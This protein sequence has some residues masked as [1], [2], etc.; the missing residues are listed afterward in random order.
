MGRLS[1]IRNVIEIGNRCLCRSHALFQLDVRVLRCFSL[2]G[3]YFRLSQL[4]LGFLQL[5]SG[6]VH[7]LHR[8]LVCLSRLL[9]QLLP[10]IEVADGARQQE[11][12]LLRSTAFVFHFL[13]IIVSLRGFDAGL[14]HS[15]NQMSLNLLLSLQHERLCILG[16]S[17]RRLALNFLRGLQ[18]FHS[19]LQGCGSFGDFSLEISLRPFFLQCKFRSD[20]FQS[21]HGA[22]VCL[23]RVSGH[24]LVACQ[25]RR[26]GGRHVLA[27]PK[28][29]RRLLHRRVQ[30]RG[31]CGIRLP[32]CVAPFLRS[33][34]SF[35]G[36]LRRITCLLFNLCQ[37]GRIL[38]VQRATRG[39]VAECRRCGGTLLCSP[40][41]H[42]V[43]PG[44]A[45]RILRVRI[46]RR[47][48]HS[49]GGLGLPA[50][51]VGLRTLRLLGG[52]GSLSRLK[53]NFS[54]CHS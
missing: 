52:H 14:V 34:Q 29:R 26:H 51:L 53:L 11:V 16:V 23:R 42:L 21:G 27:L 41:L 22:A 12:E 31:R 49:Q 17:L 2:R 6:L 30:L 43:R 44:T 46:Q 48:R 32:R 40:H 28:I 38:V 4:L 20:G 37:G 54:K 10:M 13:C 7:C 47:R 50:H 25:A 39:H 18:C 33:A 35:N 3:G 24:A 15:L 1:L 19:R 9:R 45:S 8:V 36:R 5:C